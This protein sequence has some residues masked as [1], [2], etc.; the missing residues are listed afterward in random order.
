LNRKFFY[1]TGYIIGAIVLAGYWAM[2][3]G[4]AADGRIFAY[5]TFKNLTVTTSG[6][7]IM[8]VVFTVAWFWTIPKYW[9][10][11]SNDHD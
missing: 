7:F 3:L 5:K 4:Y 10:G 1:R 6:L 8:L 2:A 11:D 9:N